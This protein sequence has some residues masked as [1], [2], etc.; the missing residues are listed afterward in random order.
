[1]NSGTDSSHR[2]TGHHSLARPIKGI[3]R[4]NKTVI[5]ARFYATQTRSPPKRESNSKIRSW[6]KPREAARAIRAV[7]G[8]PPRGQ[9]RRRWGTADP[10]FSGKRYLS[11]AGCPSQCKPANEASP[12][13]GAPFILNGFG[14]IRHP[15]ALPRFCA[16]ARAHGKRF[17]FCAVLVSLL[18]TG[19][20]FL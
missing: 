5:R 11:C 18:S 10:N 16:S 7:T 6:L 19:G 14:F 8:A 2:I 3:L 12:R 4:R 17:S 13:P 15:L 20:S 9:R 1:M